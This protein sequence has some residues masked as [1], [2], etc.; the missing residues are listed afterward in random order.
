MHDYDIFW[1]LLRQTSSYRMNFKL[2]L[3]VN[4]EAP[5]FL[6]FLLMKSQEHLTIYSTKLLSVDNLRLVDKSSGKAFKLHICG[7]IYIHF[8]FNYRNMVDQRSEKIKGAHERSFPYYWLL[9][10]VSQTVR[11]H[12]QD[13]VFLSDLHLNTSYHTNVTGCLAFVSWLIAAS[14]ILDYPKCEWLMWWI[15]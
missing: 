14:R 15:A 12:Y 1:I 8:F 13:N 3:N 2:D 10:H 6:S 9:I 7:Y 11:L 5:W 4:Q